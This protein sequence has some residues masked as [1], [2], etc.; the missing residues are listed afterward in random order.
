M[1]TERFLHVWLEEQG[2]DYDVAADLDLHRDPDLLAR[3]KVLAINGH[4]EYWSIPALEGVDRFL[5]GGGRAVVLSGNT[6]FWRVSFSP[7]G[8]VME[9]RKYD[10]AIGG[11]TSATIGELWHSDDGRR[12]SLLRECGYP[13]WK[14]VGL[15][16]LGWWDT[17]AGQFGVY[18]TALPNHF[19][20]QRPKPVGLGPGEAFGSG[21]DGREPRGVGHEADVRLSTLRRVTTLP[22]PEQAA[23]PETEPAGIETLALG[24][25]RPANGMIL[26]YFTRPT[27]TPDGVCAEMIYWERPAGGQVF[28]GGAIAGGWALSA[29]P[30]FQTLLG[31]VLHHFGLTP[32]S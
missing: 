24:I 2:Y 19:L 5:K 1:R 32:G 17:G 21:P 25:R 14:F 27:K 6:M 3:H 30:K 28:H 11:G 20:F 23:L 7:D 22:P 16:C 4:S 12:G 9:C 10:P 18:E 15:E 29:D 31:N 8:Q 13:A 26:D